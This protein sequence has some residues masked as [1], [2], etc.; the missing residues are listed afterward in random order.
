MSQEDKKTTSRVVCSFLDT[1]VTSMGRA[2]HYNTREEQQAA[3]LQV[4]QA[5]L[6][7]HRGL[8]A[9]FLILPGLT[10]R[11]KQIGLKNL[12]SSKHDKNPLVTPE[13]E[14]E[15]VYRLFQNLPPTRMLRAIEGFRVGDKELGLKKAN[16]ARTRKLILRTLLSSPRLT[17]WAVKYQKKVK[18]ALTHAWGQK[19][20]TRIREAIRREAVLALNQRGAEDK[21]IIKREILRYAGDN[22]GA[23]EAVGF[24]LGLREEVKA[25]SRLFA[26]YL[27]AREDIKKGKGLPLEVLEGIRGTFHKDVTKAELLELTK[28]SMTKT[29]RKNVQAQA[30]KA[31]V[32]VEMD[33]LDYEA[34]ELYIY[35]FECGFTNEMQKALM[36][37]AQE[38][39][40]T[41]PAHYDT[42][43]L[44]VDASA[45]MAG[46]ATQKL[47]PMAATLAMRD[48]L[49]WTSQKYYQE[50][51]GGSADDL[52]PVPQG[53]TDLA[54]GLVKLLEYEPEAVFVLSDGYENTPAG[55]FSEVVGAVRE[56]GIGTPIYHLNP[57][58]AAEATGIRDLA[59]GVPSLPAQ[60]P[61]VLGTTFLRGLIETDPV[62]GINVLLDR[63]LP[64]RLPEKEVKAVPPR[65]VLR[66]RN[67][68]VRP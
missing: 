19:K 21:D 54:D 16:N 66:P 49:V 33:P 28:D 14:Q 55:R 15:V 6:Q 36:S 32:E 45:S 13:M 41:F 17:L 10:D 43:G 30:K 61:A 2:T 4:H 67:E 3:E 11:S 37:K 38:A 50:I 7:M 5:L 39:A 9:A 23:V 1:A 52:R 59:D 8:Y 63:V 25:T 40:K 24:A 51:I 44:L 65:I 60:T 12:L 58:F 53:D 47:R 56:L 26:A 20:A 68:E 62:K 22:K 46:H 42:I 57:V 35:G 31:G 48:M 34:V 64:R 27:D 29:Q 18:A